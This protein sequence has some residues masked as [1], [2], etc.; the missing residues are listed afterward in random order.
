[1]LAGEQ[2][3][4]TLIQKILDF[5]LLLSCASPPSPPL[6]G[7]MG[8]AHPC[9]PTAH[10][11]LPDLLPHLEHLGLISD[12]AIIQHKNPPPG[13]VPRGLFRVS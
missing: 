10:E 5:F 4:V 13:K 3:K 1:M 9:R 6:S 7:R 11:L 2:K 8:R 12:Q